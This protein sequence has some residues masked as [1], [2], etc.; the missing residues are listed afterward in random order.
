MVK[1]IKDFEIE[2]DRDEVCRCLGYRRDQGPN[3]SISSLIGEEIDKAY[4]LIRPS[5]FYQLMEV[6][7]VRRP[8]VIL[9]DGLVITSEVLSRVLSRCQ[10][11]AFFLVNIGQSLEERV[12]QLMNEGQM[13][14]ATILDAIGSEAAE[15]TACYLEDKVRELAT[16]NGA[17][18]T[19]RYSPGYC[20]WD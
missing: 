7:Q 19:L 3:S 13:L 18:I 8:R 14:K 11:V 2:I 12:A 9:E 20:D 15:K 10:Q 1:A 5:C 17:E 4:E 6:R 16:S